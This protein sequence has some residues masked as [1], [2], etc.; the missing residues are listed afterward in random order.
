MNWLVKYI[1]VI[2]ITRNGGQH[3]VRTKKRTGQAG[4]RGYNKT[5]VLELELQSHLQLA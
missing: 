2:E 4:A 1:I 3:S 5:Q